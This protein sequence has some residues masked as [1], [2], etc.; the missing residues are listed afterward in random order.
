[1]EDGT[2]GSRDAGDHSHILK[3]LGQSPGSSSIFHTNT[4]HLIE[5]RRKTCYDPLEM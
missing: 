4:A 2:K 5:K 1:M 3:A